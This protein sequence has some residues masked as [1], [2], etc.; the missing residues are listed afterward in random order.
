[1][2]IYLSQIRMMTGNGMRQDI[3]RKFEKRFRVGAI[4]EFYGST[5]GNASL[6]TDFHI[7]G[8]LIHKE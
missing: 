2:Y 1:M 3:W 5:E 6:G 7:I 8:L 4:R